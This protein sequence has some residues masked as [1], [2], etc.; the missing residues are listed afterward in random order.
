MSPR[1]ELRWATATGLLCLLVMLGL[2]FTGPLA[3]IGGLLVIAV[4]SGLRWILVRRASR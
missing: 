2:A 1:F 4:S 3:I